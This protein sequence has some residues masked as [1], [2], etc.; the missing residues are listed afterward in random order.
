M[1]RLA[2]TLTSLFLVACRDNPTAPDLARLTG[3]RALTAS[4][5]AGT[6]SSTEFDGFDNNCFSA[7][8]TKFNATPGG[9]VHFRVSNENRWV[10]G[11]PL[12]DGVETNTGAANIN[13]TGQGVVHL[14]SSLKPDAV[15]GTWEIQTHLS[16]PDF[17]G[18]GVG[19]GTGDLQGMTIKFTTEPGGGTSVCNPDM[20]RGAVH[21]VILSPAS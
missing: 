17:I 5:A 15:N 12:I 13:S 14:T 18:F 1:R 10:T 19:H 9:T 4:V 20:P 2:L 3:P 7:D 11:N 16:L 6:A 8:L 21:G